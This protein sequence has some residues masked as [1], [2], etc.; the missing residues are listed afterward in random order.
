MGKSVQIY[1]IRNLDALVLR[2]RK[3]ATLQNL[4]ALPIRSVR[5]VGYLFSSDIRLV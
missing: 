1:D 2:L 5:G 3:K 4:E